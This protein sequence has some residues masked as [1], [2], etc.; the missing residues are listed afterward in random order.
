MA[1]DYGLSDLRFV[2]YDNEALA[3]QV[4]GLRQGAGSETLNNA[5]VALMRLAEG[6]ADTDKAL[7]DQLKQI[8]VSW[9]G[10]ASAGGTTATE[11]ASI[12]AEQAQEPVTDSAKGVDSQGAAFHVTKHG[13]PDA[14]TLRGPTE[15]S[16]FDQFAGFLGHTTDHAKDVKATNQARDRAVDSMNGY[17]SNSSDALGRSQ[18]LPVPPGMNLVA[19]PVDTSTHSSGA[20]VYSPS[21]GFTPAAGGSGGGPATSF[22]PGGGAASPTPTLGTPPV[23]GPVTGGGPG[24]PLLPTNAANPLAPALRAANPMLMAE[25]ATM[26]GAGGASGAGAGAQGDRVS[27]GGGGA[28]G[29]VKGAMPLGAAPEEEARAA[30]NAEKFGART[31]RAPGSIMQPAA[32]G[33]GRNAEGEEDQEHVRRYGIDSGDV[34]DDDR[35]V[36][37]ESIGDDD[38]ER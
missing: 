6:L 29:P 35:V 12:Y 17:Q 23:A 13:A 10:E 31:G 21:G 32:A 3:R 11:T 33:A 34:F 15:E 22:T 25:A 19:Q 26:M 30:R 2:A 16:G 36:A 5:V 27:R 7:R 9:Q 8:G 37:P 4:E 14:G 20:G 1:G 18:A 38:D 24:N 28:K